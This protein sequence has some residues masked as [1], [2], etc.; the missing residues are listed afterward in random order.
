L[1]AVRRAG[2]DDQKIIDWV[3]QK[4]KDN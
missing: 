3:V 4:V 1:G 2:D